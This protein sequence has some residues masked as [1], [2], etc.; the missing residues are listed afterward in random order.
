[1]GE[2]A[3][4]EGNI[5]ATSNKLGKCDLWRPQTS[6]SSRVTISLTGVGQ[7]AKYMQQSHCKPDKCG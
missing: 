1:M 3:I 6:A 5:G 7:G 2:G 4:D